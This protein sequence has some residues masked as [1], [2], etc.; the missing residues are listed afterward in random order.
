MRIWLFYFKQFSLAQVHSLNVK[1]SLAYVVFL[2][3]YELNVRTVLFQTIQFS[4]STLFSS[5]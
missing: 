1:N 4:I 2:F 5:I 3:T